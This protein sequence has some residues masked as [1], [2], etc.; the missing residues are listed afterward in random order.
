MKYPTMTSAKHN[1]GWLPQTDKNVT[2]HTYSNNF[3]HIMQYIAIS[4]SIM[5][6][7]AHIPVFRTFLANFG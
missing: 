3:R 6:Y 5:R 2:C 1:F 7:H 4:Q